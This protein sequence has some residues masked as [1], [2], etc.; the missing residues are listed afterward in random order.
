M[1]VE[2]TLKHISEKYGRDIFLDTNRLIGLFKDYSPELKKESKLLKIAIDLGVFNKIFYIREYEVESIINKF[3]WIMRDSYCIDEIWAKQMM[4]WIVN[5]MGHKLDNKVFD[6]VIYPSNTEKVQEDSDFIDKKN[7]EKKLKIATNMPY[8]YM[9]LHQ[10]NIYKN[11][12]IKIPDNIDIVYFDF[13]E[14][15]P[16]GVIIDC[17]NAE[18][19]CFSKHVEVIQKGAI[20]EYS[21]VKYWIFI[22]ENSKRIVYDEDLF[23]NSGKIFCTLADYVIRRRYNA[24]CFDN[25]YDKNLQ[26]TDLGKVRTIVGFVERLPY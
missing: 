24:V 21:N 10:K 22:K 23:T 1:N 26:K 12:S 6:R 4:I 7:I 13:V 3:V 15:I 18:V 11:Q 19:V 20:Q 5:S 17:N 14:E 25:K 16:Q 8:T 2:E 9:Q